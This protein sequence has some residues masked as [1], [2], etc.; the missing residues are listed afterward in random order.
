MLSGGRGAQWDTRAARCLPT[1]HAIVIRIRSR[2]TSKGGMCTYSMHVQL[3]SRAEV[4]GDKTR[5]QKGEVG[6]KI[7]RRKRRCRRP[8]PGTSAFMRFFY[9]IDPSKHKFRKPSSDA[10]NDG[11]SCIHCSSGPY[12][13]IYIHIYIYIYVYIYIYIYI[14]IIYI[15][16][17][18]YIYIYIKDCCFSR[19]LADGDVHDAL[20]SVAPRRHV[21]YL[22]CPPPTHTG[23]Q[24]NSP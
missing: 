23:R 5:R 11:I 7:R 13:Y 10:A 3:N 17:H 19:M 22:I 12:I 20:H 24:G 2:C 16:I 21:A 15:S 4:F 14:Y 1:A 18:P 6:D 9:Y 8:R